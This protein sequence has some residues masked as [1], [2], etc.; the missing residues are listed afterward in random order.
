MSASE[1]SQTAQF[2]LDMPA[3]APLDRMPAWCLALLFGGVVLFTATG[4]DFLVERR[5]G[6][7]FGNIDAS[8]SVAAVVAA[9]SPAG[10][11]ER[12]ATRASP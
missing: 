5:P 10:M 12:K 6:S 3:R 1:S 4:L 9:F 7:F 11:P 8:A 2:T